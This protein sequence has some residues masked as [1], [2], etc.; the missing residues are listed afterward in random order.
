MKRQRKGGNW[1]IFSDS[2]EALVAVVTLPRTNWES[3]EIYFKASLEEDWPL[4][5]QSRISERVVAGECNLSK[6]EEVVKTV[7]RKESWEFRSEVSLWKLR[8]SPWKS[9]FSALD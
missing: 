9:W 5:S 6:K 7:S 3:L 1:L 4:E 2:W 8:C